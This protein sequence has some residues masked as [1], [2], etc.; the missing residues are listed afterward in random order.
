MILFRFTRKTILNSAS[1][2]FGVPLVL[3]LFVSFAVQSNTKE[4]RPKSTARVASPQTNVSHEDA[5]KSETNFKNIPLLTSEIDNLKAGDRRKLSINGVDYIFRWIP[6]GEFMMGSP[7]SEKGRHPY[8]V[9]H[10]V[11]I[12]SGFWMLETE[13]TEEMWKSTMSEG[14]HINVILGE[15]THIDGVYVASG[16]RYPVGGVNIEKCQDFIARLNKVEERPQGFEFRLP[17]EEEWEY[18]CRAGTTTPFSFGNSLSGNKANCD[19]L[20]SYKEGEARRWKS[21]VGSYPANPWGLYDMHGNLWEWTSSTY[22]D[23]P[24]NKFKDPYASRG[25]QVVRGGSWHEI[26]QECRSAFREWQAPSHIA[27]DLGFRIVLS[28]INEV[29]E[30]DETSESTDNPPS[31]DAAKPI[32]VSPAPK[33][34][35]SPSGAASKDNGAFKFLDSPTQK[36][37]NP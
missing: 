26:T 16:P 22:K 19:D 23:Y 2:C 27:D 14:S 32:P 11:N 37:T 17:T 10:K 5:E 3:F 33:K 20:Y 30:I 34:L 25:F 24:G 13:V 1:L 6:Q 28:K 31:K 21:E 35:S 12:N 7:E 8:E 36:S 18:A 4:K 29:S 15:V 9:L